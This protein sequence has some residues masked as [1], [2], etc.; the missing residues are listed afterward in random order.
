M[1]KTNALCKTIAVFF[2]LTLMTVL[3]ATA[4]SAQDQD[5]EDPTSSVDTI[6]DLLTLEDLEYVLPLGSRERR[7]FIEFELSLLIEAHDFDLTEKQQSTLIDSWLELLENHEPQ[8][9]YIVPRDA[10]WRSNG[11]DSRETRS[12]SRSSG[13]R[14]STDTGYLNCS[15]VYVDSIGLSYYGIG[16]YDTIHFEPSRVGRTA[17]SSQLYSEMI[18]CLKRELHLWPH[19]KS[20]DSIFQQLACHNFGQLIGGG[21]TWDLEGHRGSK[22]NWWWGVWSHRCNW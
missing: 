17:S 20:W 6:Q 18:S 4:V 21:P 10:K 8:A 14:P 16:G 2:T 12:N 1:I 13:E 19:V 3:S 11:S 22:W 9:D 15:S 7:E 5:E